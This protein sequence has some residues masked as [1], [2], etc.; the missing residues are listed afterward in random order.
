M[1]IVQPDL[2]IDKGWFAGPWDSDLDISIGY[3]NTG[4]NEP[5]YHFVIQSPGLQG[6]EA[7]ADKVAAGG[8]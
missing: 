5:H 4:V 8:P 3:A 7:R 6:E 2:A 1:R